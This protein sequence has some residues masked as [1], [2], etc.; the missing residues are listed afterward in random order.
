MIVNTSTPEEPLKTWGEHKTKYNK[1]ELWIDYL[2]STQATHVEKQWKDDFQTSLNSI[3]LIRIFNYLHDQYL[4]GSYTNNFVESWQK[5]LKS[6][7]LGNARKYLRDDL[8]SILLQW[9]PD[10]WRKA[11]RILGFDRI[12]QKK[13]IRKQIASGI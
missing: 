1:C 8:A 13:T 11:V 4:M 6:L 2:N 9:A 5:T 10:F 3:I 7:F 12:T